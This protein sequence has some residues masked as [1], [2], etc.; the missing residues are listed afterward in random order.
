[1]ERE[2]A[3]APFLASPHCADLIHQQGE[4]EMDFS[5]IQAVHLPDSFSFALQPTSGC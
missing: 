5:G 2:E 4:D 3:R 1:M